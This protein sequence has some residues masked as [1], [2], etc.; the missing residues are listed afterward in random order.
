MTMT[1][2]AS[3][4]VTLF[5]GTAAGHG[6]MTHPPTR[7]PNVGPDFAG[8]G[9]EGSVFCA[10]LQHCTPRRTRQLRAHGA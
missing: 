2:S 5:I 8:L 7:F 10:W 4:F 6:M 9:A 3:L 1:M